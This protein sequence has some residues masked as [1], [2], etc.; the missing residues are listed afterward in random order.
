MSCTNN[1]TLKINMDGKARSPVEVKCQ[2]NGYSIPTSISDDSVKSLVTEIVKNIDNIKNNG[3]LNNTYTCINQNNASNQDGAV[4]KCNGIDNKNSFFL[5][6][7]T[8]NSKNKNTAVNWW[9]PNFSGGSCQLPQSEGGGLSPI[10]PG[11]NYGTCCTKETDLNCYLNPNNKWSSSC[12]D[13]KASCAFLAQNFGPL[14]DNGDGP[15][16]NFPKDLL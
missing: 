11:A 12:I 13:P 4:I 15:P 6:D 8:A 9:S 2:N 1:L 3:S 5:M 14:C 10:T 7:S 16:E